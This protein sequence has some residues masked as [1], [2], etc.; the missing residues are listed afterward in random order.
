MTAV[1]E[2]M[3]T[4]A[5][6]NQADTLALGQRI[7]RCAQGGLVIALHGDLGAG[8]TTLT[9]GIAAGMGIRS[10]I[11]SPTFTL[12]NEYAAPSDLRLVHVD[13]YR[14]GEAGVDAALDGSMIGL[15][16][17][18]D[19]QDSVLVVEWAERVSSLLPADHLAISLTLV[20]GSDD[21]RTIELKANGAVSAS[22]LACLAAASA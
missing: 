6:K 16:D 13:G 17:L 8:K 4:V 7:G 15:E 9:Q 5:S 3:L 20:D 14:L 19:A 10:R 2:N 12:V 1:V 22:L 21:L 11:T 18:L